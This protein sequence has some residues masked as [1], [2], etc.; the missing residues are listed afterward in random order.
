MKRLFDLLFSSVALIF[1]APVLLV[2]FVLV[3]VQLGSPVFFTQI[4]PGLYG[5]PFKIIKFRTMDFNCDDS[6]QLLP[7]ANR[8]TPLGRILRHT[9]L[10]ELPELWNV[11]LGQMSVVGP[12]PLRM[13][14]LPLYTTHQTRRHDARPGITGWAQING[15]NLLSWEKKFDLD[16]WYVDNQSLILDIKIIFLTIKKVLTREG[17]NASAEFSMKPFT[18]TGGSKK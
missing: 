10:D 16:I 15:R 12:R 14:Y 3:R 4:R 1:F 7:D 8:L 13:E 17:I 18:G 2:I 9:S 6:E 5:K 11:V